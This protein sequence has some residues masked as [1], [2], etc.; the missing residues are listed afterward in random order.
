MSHSVPR[1]DCLASTGLSS[2][3][4]RRDQ[5]QFLQFFGHLVAHACTPRSEPGL[6][7]GGIGSAHVAAGYSVVAACAHASEVGSGAGTQAGGGSA[8]GSRGTT[9]TRCPNYH[10]CYCS[11]V[12]ALACRGRSHERGGR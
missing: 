4:P 12:A 8:Q 2:L 9:Q 5:L 10:P 3:R 11:G 6:P 7:S 1:G